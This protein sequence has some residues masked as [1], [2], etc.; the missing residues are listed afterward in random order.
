M[1]TLFEL[2]IGF[3][4]LR[5]EYVFL[6]ALLVALL[7]FLPIFGVGTVLLPWGIFSL[8]VGNTALGVGLLV[9]YV[10][11]TVLRQAIEPHFVGKSLGLHPIL[12]LVAIYAGIKLLGI[13][14]FLAGPLLAIIIKAVLERE[15]KNEANGV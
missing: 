1:I 15:L 7:D 13:V 11:I 9:L 2:C 10:V 4:L 14:G 8:L 12:M 5:V 6:L 3:L